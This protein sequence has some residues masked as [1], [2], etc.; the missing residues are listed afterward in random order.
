LGR[1]DVFQGKDPI[2]LVLLQ[3]RKS[4]TEIAQLDSKPRILLCVP[5]PLCK[6]G[7]VEPA[8]E[9]LVHGLTPVLRKTASDLKLTLV[10]LYEPLKDYPQWSHPKWAI[11]DGNAQ[12]V[13]ASRFYESITGLQAPYALLPPTILSKKNIS[14]NLLHNPG[15]EENQ[16]LWRT[17]GSKLEI[18]SNLA[19]RGKRALLVKERKEEWHG[20][21]LDVTSVLK[22]HGP[23]DYLLRAYLRSGKAGE[24]SIGK[25][26]VVIT[27]DDTTTHRPQVSGEIRDDEWTEVVGVLTLDW[28]STV[29]SIQYSVRLVP[30]T[31][32]LYVD[33]MELHKLEYPLPQ[34]R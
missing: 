17:N 34:L 26:V 27:E 6:A 20:P 29:K 22:K 3:A 33:E 24:K 1:L 8:N 32:D 10:D 13:I 28:S 23:G 2:D 7:S 19:Y 9:K 4:L 30:K 25:I 31:A 18:V 14:S 15:L 21:G 11:P 16:S 5:P 12:R